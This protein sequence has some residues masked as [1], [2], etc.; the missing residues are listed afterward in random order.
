MV[1]NLQCTTS[2]ERRQQGRVFPDIRTAN[3][4]HVVL[5]LRNRP[6][7]LEV[8]SPVCVAIHET[9]DG[10]R[11]ALHMHS[12]TADFQVVVLAGSLPGYTP[13]GCDSPDIVSKSCASIGLRA[14]DML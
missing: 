14:S 4:K 12:V 7:I 2:G 1:G 3:G 8:R 6:V 5:E 11:G 13:V 10:V 9:C